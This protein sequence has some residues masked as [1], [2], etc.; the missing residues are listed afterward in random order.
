MRANWRSGWALTLLRMVIG[1]HFLYEGVF[2][3]LLGKSWSA[4][5]FLSDS[6]WRLAP[7]FRGLT[8]SSATLHIVDLLNMWGLTLIGLGLMLGVFTRLSAFAG[9]VL[10][11]LYYLANPPFIG[12]RGMYGEGNYL[13]IN[14][15]LIEIAVLL[16]FVLIPRGWMYGLDGIVRSIRSRQKPAADR[17]AKVAPVEAPADEDP[18]VTQRRIFLRDLAGIPA[19]GA[20]WYTVDRKR[21]WDSNEERIL[22]EAGADGRTSATLKKFTFSRLKDLTGTMTYGQIGSLKLSRLIMG[23]NLIGGWAHSRDLV[24]V[25]DLVK[26]YHTDERVI[27]TFRLAEKCGINTFLTHPMLLRIARK[28]WDEYGGKI[29]FVS[30]CGGADLDAAVKLSLAGGAHAA[31]V[32]GGTADRL[33]EEGKIDDIRRAVETIRAAGK[34]AGVGG[35]RIK[36]IQACVD[37]GIQPDFWMKT[38]HHHNYWSSRTTEG[39]HDNNFC[40]EPEE[41]IKFMKDLPQPW[42]AFKVMAAGAIKPEDG[43]QYAFKN[44]ADFICAGMYDFQM[45]ADVNLVAS[46]LTNLAKS[47]DRTRPWRAL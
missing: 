17:T 27:N 19:L 39:D 44:G 24:Y 46:I 20:F 31:Y 6:T 47:N 37:K 14:R 45:V 10:L 30:D 26:A 18:R 25:S 38:L 12:L 5:D 15:N 9:A 7:Y 11:T 29:Q 34:P 16:A 22:V 28:Y 1:W 23:G 41:T 8:E 36:T 2:K 13:I 21:K 40:L 43:F 4:A 32:Q 35:H 42:I 33:V 3:V